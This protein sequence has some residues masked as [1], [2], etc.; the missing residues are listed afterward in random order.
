MS[1]WLWF[2]LCVVLAVVGGIDFERAAERTPGRLWWVRVG[3]R[4][5]VEVWR[6]GIGVHVVITDRA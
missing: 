3:Q 6:R 4:R 1:A 2:G 5:T